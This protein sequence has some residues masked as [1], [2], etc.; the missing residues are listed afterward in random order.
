MKAKKNSFRDSILITL[1]FLLLLVAMNIS[2]VLNF[3]EHKHKEPQYTYDTKIFNLD[4][5][6]EFERDVI[7]YMC[8]NNIEVNFREPANYN[9]F[10]GT[11]Y[12]S[13]WDEK[14]YFGNTIKLGRKGTCMLK[15]RYIK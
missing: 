3:T 8:D 7:E 1:V 4:N 15:Y 10:R 13:T 6:N 12:I 14:P 11:I 2:F 9:D 5:S